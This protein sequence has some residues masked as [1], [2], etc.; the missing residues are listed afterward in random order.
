MRSKVNG[1]HAMRVRR[2]GISAIE[3][4]ILIGGLTALSAGGYVLFSQNAQTA[5]GNAGQALTGTAAPGSSGN[6]SYA[7][8]SASIFQDHFRNNGNLNA[9]AW[10]TQGSTWQVQNGRLSVGFPTSTQEDKA[11]ARDSSGS[12]C[13]I[14]LNAELFAGNGFGVIFRESGDPA[15]MNGYTFQYDPGYQGG[16]FIMRKWINGV[17]IWP[18]F[19]AVSPPAGYQWQGVDRQIEV[20]AA[21]STFTAMI[22]GKT[23]LTGSDSTYS[24]GA[25]GLRVWAGGQASFANF[26]VTR[27]GESSHGNED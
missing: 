26:S 12:N 24:S 27:I 10:K 16:Q 17:E 11:I 4:S 25:A 22:D 20:D 21:G 19:V 18:P 5:L 9:D 8:Q 3:Y 1:E 6:T 23:V 2:L 13:A 7:V 14:T 15:S